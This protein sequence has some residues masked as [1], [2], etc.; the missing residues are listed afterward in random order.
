[1]GKYAQSTADASNTAALVEARDRYVAAMEEVSTTSTCM[2][3]VGRAMQ[4]VNSAVS[5]TL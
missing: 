5:E 2:S 3:V 1:V 4:E